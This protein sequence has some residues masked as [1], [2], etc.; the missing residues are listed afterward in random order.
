MTKTGKWLGLVI[1]GVIYNRI[2]A[3]WEFTTERKEK[4]DY[5]GNMED[6]TNL[7]QLGMYIITEIER[8]SPYFTGFREFKKTI[9][10]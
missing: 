2:G 3:A 9:E 7:K 4:S 5:L 6:N 1:D 10:R 8:I